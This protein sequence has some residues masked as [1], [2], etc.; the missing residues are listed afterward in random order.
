[1]GFSFVRIYHIKTLYGYKVTKIALNPTKAFYKILSLPFVRYNIF[2]C[3]KKQHYTQRFRL[4]KIGFI[5]LFSSSLVFLYKN[6]LSIKMILTMQLSLTRQQ[7]RWSFFLSIVFSF[8][9]YLLD[10]QVW[11]IFYWIGGMKRHNYI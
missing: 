2:W 9:L 7:R 3:T 5:R 8:V 6:T 11:N 1:M 4:L 10:V